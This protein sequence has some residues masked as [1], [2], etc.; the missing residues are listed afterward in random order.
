MTAAGAPLLVEVRDGVAWAT[1]N[2]PE[3][4]NAFD[5]ALHT[6]LTDFLDSA[7]RDGDLRGVV[8]TGAGR[9][10]S[11]GG[12]LEWFTSIGSAELDRLF[13]EGRRIIE[14]MLDLT[15]PV[16]SAVNGPAVGLGAT[17]ALFSDAVV[18]SSTAQ[19]GDPHVRIGVTAGDGGAVIWPW[20]TG[21]AHAKRML[22]TGRMIGA[23]EALRINLITAV[24]EPDE[25]LT[26]ASE[27]M[28]DFLGIPELAFSSTKR[29]LHKILK[30]TTNLVLDASLAAEKECFGTDEHRA[31]VKRFAAR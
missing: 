27:I 29:M 20:L 26:A 7:V 18:M 15:I 30:D 28:D 10:F 11:G 9:A 22:L 21:M 13:D 4:L 19:I 5:G 6:H 25:L 23:E 24:A 1:L 8:L 2:R 17:L 16:V 12:D 14:S 3:R 31:L